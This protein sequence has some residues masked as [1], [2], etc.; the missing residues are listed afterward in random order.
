MRVRAD[1]NFDLSRTNVVHMTVKPADF[2][3]EDDAAGNK[4][5][6]KGG[7]IRTRDGGDGGAGCRCVIL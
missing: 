5:G 6:A 1:Y 3:D 7:S 4:H 2:G